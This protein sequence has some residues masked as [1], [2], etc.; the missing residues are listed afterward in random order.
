MHYS[1]YTINRDLD[2]VH[3]DL[4]SAKHLAQHKSIKPAEDLPGL[5]QW[6]CVEC[7]KWFE[8]E[9]NLLQHRRGKNHKRRL[10]LVKAHMFIIRRSK[11]LTIRRVRLL[12]E[13]PHTQKAAESAIGLQTDNGRR[14]EEEPKD[15]VHEPTA[16]EIETI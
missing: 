16:M 10:V 7:A 12:R 2:Q 8:G 4:R 9:H 1:T 5:G 6:Y 15:T 3:A 13:E 11:V 14:K